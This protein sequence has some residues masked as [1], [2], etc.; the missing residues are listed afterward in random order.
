MKSTSGVRI[1]LGGVKIY[2][3]ST[4]QGGLP[5]LSSREPEL[6][7]MAKTAVDAQYAKQACAEMGLL[8]RI[9]MKT[10]AQAALQNA[11]KLGPD[12]IRHLELQAAYLILEGVRAQE[13]D[14]SGENA[15]EG[16]R[17]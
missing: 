2:T 8:V 5:A 9:K 4:T 17:L 12:R 16:E 10:D 14:P 13:I 15:R 1:T 7:S 11:S 3:S 6:R